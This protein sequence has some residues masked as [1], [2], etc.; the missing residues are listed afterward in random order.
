MSISYE[1]VVKS[2]GDAVSTDIN[3]VNKWQ[4]AAVNV[5]GFYKTATALDEVKAQ[6]IADAILPRIGK[7]HVNAL[8]KELPRKGSKEFKELDSHGVAQ[9]ETANQAKKDARATIHTMFNRVKGYAFPALKDDTENPPK[10]LK[11]KINETIANLVK[12]CQKAEDATF[13][14]TSVIGALENVLTVVN[15]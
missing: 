15:K 10:D 11:T 2:V 4:V 5:S 6:F 9:W 1:S 12:A 8:D 14:I 7:H 3:A 13:D